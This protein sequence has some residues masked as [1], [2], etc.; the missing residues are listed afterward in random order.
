MLVDSLPP[1]YKKMVAEKK[2]TMHR[3]PTC[4]DET[5]QH[6]TLTP[7]GEVPNV[8]KKKNMVA[9][10]RQNLTSPF[11]YFQGSNSPDHF[12]RGMRLS[13]SKRLTTFLLKEPPFL[14][15]G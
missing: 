13:S 11:F 5:F 12:F 6:E 14:V 9:F 4:D 15:G 10:G 8:R 1:T 7:I 2:Q 3:V